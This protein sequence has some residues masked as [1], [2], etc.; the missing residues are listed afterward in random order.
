M[1]Y[2]SVLQTPLNKEKNPKSR[3][4]T[5][6]SQMETIDEQENQRKSR[7]LNPVSDQEEQIEVEGT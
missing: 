1:N 5:S 3:E 2:P 6:S 4:E 7:K